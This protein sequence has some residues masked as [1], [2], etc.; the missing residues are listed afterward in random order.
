MTNP[1]RVLV[2]GL[3]IL[4][5]ISSINAFQNENPQLILKVIDQNQATVSE[6]KIRLV[7]KNKL[8][9]KVDVSSSDAGIISLQNT[10]N[11][12]LEIEA[13]GFQIYRETIEILPGRNTKRIILQVLNIDEK[14]E[15]D[16]TKQEK[17]TDPRNGAFTGFLT[18]EEINALPDD[19][20]ALKQALKQ[21]YGQE[22]EFLVDGFSSKGLPP[23]SQIASIRVSL[24]SFDAEYHTL[25]V[26]RI[27]ITTKAFTKW[28]GIAWFGFN[29]KILN[30]RDPL[31]PIR[32]NERQMSFSTVIFGP[33]LKDSTSF[34]FTLDFDDSFSTKNIVAVLPTETI[35]NTL[36]TPSKNLSIGGKI[37]HNLNPY[38]SLNLSY[39][40]SSNNDKNLGVGGFDLPSRAFERNSSSHQVR[41][42]QTGNVGEKYFNEF[43]FQFVQET[44]ENVS[45]SHEPT[46]RVLGAFTDGGASNDARENKTSIMIADNFLFGVKNHALKVGVIFEYE[47]QNQSSQ[48]NSNGTFTFSSINDYLQNRPATFVQRPGERKIGLSQFQIGGFI[49]DDIR[50]RNNLLVSLGLRYEL[51]NNIRDLNNFSPRI[52]ASWSPLKDGS[53]AIR[54]GA[55][56]FYSWV[57]PDILLNIQSQNQDQ[58][59]EITIINPSFPNLSSIGISQTLPN[60]FL[61]KDK[62][63]KNPYVFISQFGIQKKIIGNS[64]VR[65]L[66]SFQK[67]IHQLRSRNLNAPINLIRNYP[68][69]G[70]IFQIE[71]S[72]FFAKNSVSIYFETKPTKKTYFSTSYKLS[73]SVSDTEGAFSLPSDNFNLKRDRSFSN[74]DSRHRVFSSFGWS[75]QNGISLSASFLTTS[76]T[77]INITTGTDDNN[78]T[79]FN[80]RP[81][82]VQRNSSRGTWTHKFDS[83]FQWIFSLEK[84]GQ[85]STGADGSSSMKGRTLTF[86]T[87]IENLFNTTNFDSFVGVQSSPIFLKPLSTLSPR[88]INFGL[89]FTF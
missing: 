49:Q 62:N 74:D 28:A 35:T 10:G 75:P 61:M 50:V 24:T 38:Q 56:L 39:F 48:Q 26:T 37:K 57:D 68:T 9:K 58:T 40:Y 23:K 60:S 32:Q 67:G 31:S 7:Y 21:K 20:V 18:K 77:P 71:S 72:A 88:K 41:F 43:R 47:R 70:N 79:I 1:Y 2:F 4:L 19:P 13:K 46:I 81:F 59:G 22:I 76:P 5:R 65:I 3:F 29:D 42:S 55:G 73:K 44:T 63:L 87:N 34:D 33:L 78:D 54:G 45:Q 84:K 16:V 82:G 80:D 66:Y 53:F 86:R 15:V 30:A 25:G 11:Y 36:R 8:I 6:Y 85:I 51:Q 27:E 17:N 52:G 64:E 69:L 14:V 12:D 83:S 89:T